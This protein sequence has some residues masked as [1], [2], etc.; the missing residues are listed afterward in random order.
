MD[1]ATRRQ[2]PEHC[3]TCG[4][5][6]ALTFHHLIPRKLHRRPRFRRLFSREELNRGIHVCR[7][8]HRGIH[9]SYDEMTLGQQLNSLDRL[10][11]DPVL[12][13]HFAWVARQ[14]C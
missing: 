6:T 4:R 7:A 10:R 11:A 5:V 3:A 8:C 9:R 13:R 2:R 14:K 1:S 12:T